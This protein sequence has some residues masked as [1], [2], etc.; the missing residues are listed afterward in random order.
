MLGCPPFSSS[1]PYILLNSVRFAYYRDDDQSSLENI[2]EQIKWVLLLPTLTNYIYWRRWSLD[3][4]PADSIYLWRWGH[5][6]DWRQVGVA[7]IHKKRSKPKVT[8]YTA[9]SLT[10]VQH[11]NVSFT[12]QS[13][14]PTISTNLFWKDIYL[15]IKSLHDIISFYLD[16]RRRVDMVFPDLLKTFDVV[17]H[18]RPP[19]AKIEALAIAS[20]LKKR[21]AALLSY[22]LMSVRVTECYLQHMLDSSGGTIMFS[23]GVYTFLIFVY[24]FQW[25]ICLQM[26][27]S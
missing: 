25:I 12:K 15:Q 9:V 18:R 23:S 1:Y 11:T 20:V 7:L 24:H 14:R 8:N 2:H 4:F 6:N 3:Y 17:N 19:F 22:R 13:F 27:Q 16:N 5:P 21:V 10:W 26:T